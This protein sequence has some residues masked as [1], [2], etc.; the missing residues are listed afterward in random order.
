MKAN[1]VL[2]PENIMKKMVALWVG[3]IIV[4]LGVVGLV[5]YAGYVAFH[6]ISKWW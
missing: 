4:W 5:G 1:R 6:F 2:E 3:G